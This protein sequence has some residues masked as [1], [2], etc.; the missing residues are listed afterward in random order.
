VGMGPP[1]PAAGSWGSD[2]LGEVNH[3]FWRKLL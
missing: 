1:M 2:L 3:D